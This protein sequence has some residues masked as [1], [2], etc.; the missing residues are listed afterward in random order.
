MLFVLLYELISLLSDMFCS[1]IL[2]IWLWC[3]LL[4]LLWASHW[5]LIWSLLLFQLWSLICSGPGIDYFNDLCSGL[6]SNFFF[7]IESWILNW[8]NLCCAFS[9]NLSFENRLYSWSDPDPGFPQ[10]ATLFI[11]N[12]SKASL[13]TVIYTLA[14][15]YD[16]CDLTPNFDKC[17][18]I[19]L[20]LH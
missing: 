17:F 11:A 16:P 19:F 12:R 5:S 3:I 13:S 18:A 14:P 2:V 10:V 4:Y 15:E 20:S 6:R 8:Y 7:Y 9:S 1:L